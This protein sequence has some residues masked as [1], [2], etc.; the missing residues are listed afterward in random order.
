MEDGTAV[1]Y[2]L[3]EGLPAWSR[4][5]QELS[6]SDRMQGQSSAAAGT[7]PAGSLTH[8]QAA[9]L[10]GKMRW[11]LCPCFG[12]VGLAL[13]RPLH[14]V[15][16]VASPMPDEL[17]EAVAGLRLLAGCLPPRTL[18][19]LA[20]DAPP[21]V[22]FTD[23]A[24]EAGRGTLGVVVKRPGRPLLW[25]ACDCPP[26]VLQAFAELDRPKSQYIGQLELLAAVVA[27]T[28]FADELRGE[29]VIHWIDNES[30]VYSLV[31]GYSRAPDSARVVNLFHGCVAQLEVTPWIEYVQSDDN[32]ADL[33]SRGEFE[34]LRALGGDEA[35]R[36]AIVP[37]FG[38]M[39]G[40]LAPLLSQGL[41]I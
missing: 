19:L 6:N 25:T 11:T 21:T 28:T 14:A 38:S 31:K 18:P 41:T 3:R 8:T 4:E 40:P 10:A 15:R 34:L 27:Y 2:L 32:I 16:D 37:T 26:W 17:R 29:H 35:F 13:L 1:P 9:K 12:R 23:A 33:P 22:I 7:V 24:F 30:A 36:P 20:S 5:A 39:V